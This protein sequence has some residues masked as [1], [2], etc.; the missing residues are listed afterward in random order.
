MERQSVDDFLETAELYDADGKRIDPA[1]FEYDPD[2]LENLDV[3][4]DPTQNNCGVGPGGFQPGNTCAKG[5]DGGEGVDAEHIHGTPEGASTEGVKGALAG[6]KIFDNDHDREEKRK[7][8]SKE[9]S[10]SFT[11]KAANPDGQTTYDQHRTPDGKWTP[12]RQE[13]HKKIIDDFLKEAT[14]VDEPVSYMTGGGPASGKSVA[15]KMGFM[16]VPDNHVAIDPDAIK[17]Y[18]PEYR[19]GLD[20]KDPNAA[21]FAHEESSYLGKQIMTRAV[22]NGYNTLLD[23]TGNSAIEDLTRKVAQMKQ[24][25]RKAIATYVT[26]D[27]D[28]AQARNLARAEKTGRLVPETFLRACHASVSNVFPKA[29]S[30]GLFDEVNLIDTSSGKAVRVLSAKGHKVEVH[31]NDRWEAFMSKA[32]EAEVY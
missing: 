1:T 19:R 14:P 27:T 5:G 7:R 31:D 21:A 32:T 29:I 22:E 28:I 13:L 16:P 10:D 30:A 6:A 9:I 8:T 15:L 17:T 18:I 11:G 24:G 20:S 26:V 12:E 25:G 3:V 4:D 2:W 23:G